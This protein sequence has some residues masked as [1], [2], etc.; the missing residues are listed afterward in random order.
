MWRSS[1]FA[2]GW[3]GSARH[4]QHYR[5]GYLLMAG[6]GTPLVVSVHTI[7]S[8]DFAISQLPGW[9]TT[10]FPP[11]FVAGAIFGGFA[12][13]LLQHDL[14]ASQAANSYILLAVG[15]A[16][17][18]QIPGLLISVAAAMVVSRVGKEQDIGTQI[19][20][21]VFDSPQALAVAATLALLVL[22]EVRPGP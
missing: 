16:L 5:I 15:D 6:L 14:T 11:Y 4:W 18:A 22:S 9:H 1:I 17:V 21:Q 12:I 7:V 3:R 20:G 19:R 10:I 13:G 8:F 2:F